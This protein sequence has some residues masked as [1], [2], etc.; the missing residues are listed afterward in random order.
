[1]GSSACFIFSNPHVALAMIMASNKLE[2]N[3]A[4]YWFKQEHKGEIQ[5]SS[6]HC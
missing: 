5:Q 3:S 4:I 1:M 6:E 2:G